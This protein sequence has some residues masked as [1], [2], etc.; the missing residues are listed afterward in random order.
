MR[1]KK[2]ILP[3]FFLAVSVSISSQTVMFLP[4]FAAPTAEE[5]AVYT[6]QSADGDNDNDITSSISEEGIDSGNIED[7]TTDAFNPAEEQ[8]SA[9]NEINVEGLESEQTE[10]DVRDIHDPANNTE[11]SETEM[12]NFED[13]AVVSNNDRG[14]DDTAA[15]GAQ[16]AGDEDGERITRIEPEPA[17]DADG[18]VT[19]TM[20]TAEDVVLPVTITMRGSEG[21][22]FFT[23]QESGQILKMKPDTYKLTKAIDGNGKKLPDGATLEITDEG[24][25]VYLDFNKP[26]STGFNILDFIIQNLAFIPV[27]II[28]YIA[29]QWFKK[30]YIR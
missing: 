13:E 30:H 1:K 15:N 21:E 27:V 7:E 22:I 6:E 4:V 28:L 29:F 18:N 14:G 24:G 11:G 23:V 8:E 9:E 12:E 3:A 17:L 5:T 26:E 25:Y 20:Y 10:E 2:T 16:N 19:L